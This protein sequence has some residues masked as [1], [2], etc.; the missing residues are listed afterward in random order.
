[1][2]DDGPVRLGAGIFALHDPHRGHERAFNEYYERDHMYAAAILAPWTIA[3]QRF[4]ATADLKAMRYPADGPF[5]PITDGSYLTMYWITEGHLA[6]QQAWVSEQMKLLTAAGRQFEQRSVQ[7]ATT[8]DYLGAWSRDP[9]GV[10]PFLALDHRYEGAVWA[11]IER[12]TDESVGE[13]EEWLATIHLPACFASSP[14]ALATMFTP[15]PK[16]PWWPAA[17]PEVPGVGERVVVA[18]FVEDDVHD[19]FGP[20]FADFG[21]KLAA[22]ARARALFVAPFIPTI[23]GTDAYVDQLW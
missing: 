3:G 20:W 2:A 12:T 11:V 22:T 23:P 21:D 6:D 7:T 4:V 5:G 18:F 17:A 9:D 13:L 16:E 15:R 19:A 14:V 1:M 8:Y 10:P